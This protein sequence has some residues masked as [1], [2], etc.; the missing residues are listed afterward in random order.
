MSFIVKYDPQL[1]QIQMQNCGRQTSG[2]CQYGDRVYRNVTQSSRDRLVR[3]IVR[4]HW[5]SS[6]KNWYLCHR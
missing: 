5:I 1:N 6:S 3:W 4:G 2:H